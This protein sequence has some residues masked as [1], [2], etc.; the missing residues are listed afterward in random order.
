MT[1]FLILDNHGTA[2]IYSISIESTC[3]STTCYPNNKRKHCCMQK[4]MSINKFQM[5]I[6]NSLA[7]QTQ[8]SLV[9][10]TARS[11]FNPV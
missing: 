9:L 1:F 3:G 4:L 11:S 10:Q 5:S 6:R 7:N 2:M 8:I